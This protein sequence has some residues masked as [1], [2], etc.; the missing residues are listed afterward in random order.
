MLFLL[1]KTIYFALL[2]ISLQ[3]GQ[4]AGQCAPHPACLQ[5]AYFPHTIMHRLHIQ[6]HW[7]NKLSIAGTVKTCKLDYYEQVVRFLPCPCSQ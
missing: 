5:A 4:E 3:S 1:S 7:F 6:L 2:A